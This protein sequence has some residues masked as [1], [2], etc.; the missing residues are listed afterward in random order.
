MRK[1]SFLLGLCV[2][3]M[4]KLFQADVYRGLV[5]RVTSMRVS[6]TSGRTEHSAWFMC[7]SLSGGKS[8]APRAGLFETIATLPDQ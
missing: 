4:S 6:H 1:L 7:A 5:G 2:D 3:C 8:R